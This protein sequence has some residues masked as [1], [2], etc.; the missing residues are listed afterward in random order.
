MTATT[1]HMPLI[2]AIM[3]KNVKEID[4]ILKDAKG[5]KQAINEV[6]GFRE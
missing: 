1:A 3:T 6:S 2:K 5:V 4:A